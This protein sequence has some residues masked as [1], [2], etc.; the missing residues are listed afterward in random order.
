MPE[1]S[2]NY[3]TNTL[4][5]R[6]FTLIEALIALA[7]FGILAS[8]A[9]P[10]YQHVA[11]K[12]KRAEGRAALMELMQQQERFYMQHTRYIRFSSSMDEANEKKFKWFSGASPK[13]SAYEIRAEAC[14]GDTIDHCVV[15]FAMPGT[16]NV[17]AA[18]KDAECGALS[19]SSSGVKLPAGRDCW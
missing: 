17:D 10:A 7:I 14:A 1:Q 9:Y 11:R 12:A 8:L 3:G 19:L 4:K 2:N 5:S 6:G 16:A 13:S 15:L 18:Y